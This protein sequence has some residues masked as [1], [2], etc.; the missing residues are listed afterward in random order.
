MPDGLLCPLRVDVSGYMEMYGCQVFFSLMQFFRFCAYAC[1]CVFEVFF[2][3]YFG[4]L[5]S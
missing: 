3:I 5:H 4:A 1:S 2:N